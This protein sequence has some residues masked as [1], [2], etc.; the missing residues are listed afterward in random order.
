MVYVVFT[1]HS[2]VIVPVLLIFG[3]LRLASACVRGV[4]YQYC[5]IACET[6]RPTADSV[7]NALKYFNLSGGMTIIYN[8]SVHRYEAGRTQSCV[9]LK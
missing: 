8:I 6:D 7:W 3:S 4:T 2:F 9:H 1:F 5:Y